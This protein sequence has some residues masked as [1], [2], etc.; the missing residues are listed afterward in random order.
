MNA[1]KQGERVVHPLF[2]LGTVLGDESEGRVEVR[3]DE[4]G[5][6]MLTLKYALLQRVTPEQDAAIRERKQATFETTFVFE[7]DANHFPGSRW[8][9]FYENFADDVVRK[10]A[11]IMNEARIALGVSSFDTYKAP[12]LPDSWPKAFKLRWPGLERSGLHFVVEIKPGGNAMTAMFPFIEYGTQTTVEID[13]VRIFESGVEAQIDAK[14]GAAE[15]TFY[16]TDF[17]INAG[18]YRAGLQMD[19][20]LV[21]LAY[22][23]ERA[24]EPDMVLPDDSPV[25][26]TMRKAAIEMRDDPADSS[27][28]ISFKGA[29]IFVPIVDW[30]RDDYEFRGTITEVKPY[31]MLSQD[32]WMLTVCVMRS[33][34]AND[35]EFNLRILV[36][37]RIWKEAAA[38]RLGEDVCGRLWLQGR[39]WS[40]PSRT[41]KQMPS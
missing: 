21:G 19:F 1:L 28:R 38:P 25:M 8:P 34:D 33:L 39:L 17:T 32:G 24:D 9:P 12:A 22:A 6:K 27:N 35:R 41:E 40:P 2:G 15:V 23:C 31:P 10:L 3:F 36:T 30:D 37:R 26:Q 13:T 20:I 18:W 5:Q 11:P 4:N 16:D 7:T 29:A 14:I